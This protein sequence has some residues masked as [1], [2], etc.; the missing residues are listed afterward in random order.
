MGASSKRL[1]HLR[2][3]ARG[4]G[5]ADNA[6]WTRRRFDFCLSM[7]GTFGHR[8]RRSP[9]HEFAQEIEHLRDIA[10]PDSV[11][12]RANSSSPPSPT[13]HVTCWRIFPTDT[14]GI[15]E[16]VGERLSYC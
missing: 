13:G 1:I 5:Q 12:N 10:P 11:R 16:D 7:P 14:S 8:A 2:Y 6:A 4:V 9:L 15:A 3:R